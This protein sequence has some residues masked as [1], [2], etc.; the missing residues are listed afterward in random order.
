MYLPEVLACD[1]DLSL[2]QKSLVTVRVW[3]SAVILGGAMSVFPVRERA[4]W[5]FGD[6]MG[7]LWQR[8][9]SCSPS[10]SRLLL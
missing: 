6:R 7:S 2:W 5:L 1:G 4:K 8:L 9:V 3:D 10:L